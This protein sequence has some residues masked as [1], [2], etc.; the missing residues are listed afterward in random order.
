[1]KVTSIA[2]LQHSFLWLNATCQSCF[3][4]SII[5]KM[6]LVILFQPLFGL[7]GSKFDKVWSDF[8]KKQAGQKNENHSN[9]ILRRCGRLNK[10][11]NIIRSKVQSGYYR[12][13]YTLTKLQIDL[14]S[15][16]CN[17]TL[18]NYQYF[19]LTPFSNRTPFE[20]S[21]RTFSRI[22][23]NV[24]DFKYSSDPHFLIYFEA[25]CLI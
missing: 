10:L 5:F 19:H 7:K 14:T 8:Y 23:E 17:E 12:N 15:K 2:R 22:F 25:K 1:M 16:V 11:I 20:G 13:R 3:G 18:F 21:R 24:K 6:S 4:Y 9:H